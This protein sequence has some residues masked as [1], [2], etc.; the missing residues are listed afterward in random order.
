MEAHERTDDTTFSS[1]LC[2]KSLIPFLFF[3]RAPYLP[4]YRASN[5]EDY[6]VIPSVPVPSGCLLLSV[7]PCSFRRSCNCV[8]L[9]ARRPSQRSRRRVSTSLVSF[10][11]QAVRSV[12]RDTRNSVARSL[13]LRTQLDPPRRTLP[14]GSLEFGP[15]LSLCW[16]HLWSSSLGFVVGP[17]LHTHTMPALSL[18]NITRS[19]E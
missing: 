10:L 3:P 12:R 2:N 1:S 19:Q 17:L 15:V 6:P 11:V 5:I 9:H 14:L 16:L 13:S 7:H 8:I 18:P 4:T